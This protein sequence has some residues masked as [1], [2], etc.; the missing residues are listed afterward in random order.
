MDG[1][2]QIVIEAVRIVPP[3]PPRDA[4]LDIVRGLL[5]LSIFASHA[6]G[7][8]V[9]AW[10]IHGAWGFSD[11]SEQFILLSGFTLGSVFARKS[12]RDGWAAAARDLLRRTFRLYRI[13]LLVFALFGLLMLAASLTFLPGEAAAHGWLPL[14]TAPAHAIPGVA[15]MLF[16]PDFMGILPSFVWCMLL[17]PPFAW[18]SRRFGNA[19]LLAPLAL[20]A[21]AQISGLMVPALPAGGGISFNPFAWQLL[22]LTGAWLGAR[23]LP[24]GQALRLPPRWDRALTGFAMAIVGLGLWTKLSWHGLLA[25][26]APDPMTSMID[27]KPDLAPLRALH[28]FSLAWLVARFVPRSADWMDT[29]PGRWLARIGRNSL[30]VFCLGIFLSWGAATFFRLV[31]PMTAHLL[32]LPLIVAGTLLLGLF[33]RRLERRRA[34]GGNGAARQD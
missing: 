17:L 10:F 26:P 34:T 31:P 8:V 15:L 27:W 3:R 28:A 18:L 19:A 22:Y 21:A 13:H 33:A 7:S 1:G 25:L 9:G 12:A 11:S 5:Q 29:S 24:D 14:L 2:T 4:R 16:Q 23:A 6:T 32:D 20:Y 30:E